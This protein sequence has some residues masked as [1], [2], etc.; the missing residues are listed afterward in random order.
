MVV[1]SGETVADPLT[2]TDPTPWSILANVPP[3]ELQLNIVEPPS[4]MV[5]NAEVYDSMRGGVFTVTVAVSVRDP[6]VLV[7]VMVYVVVTAGTTDVEPLKLT[8]PI[9][10]SMLAEPVFV[11][12]Q[13]SVALS[14]SEM[15]AGVAEIL[16]VGSSFTMMVTL[17]L[18]EP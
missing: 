9:S 17:E 2:A 1:T 3:V 16:A 7:A 6:Y 10:W 8:A 14:P 5:L 11:V 15:D 12:F 4:V 13:L 18:R